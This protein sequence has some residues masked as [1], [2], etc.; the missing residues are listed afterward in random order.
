MS[1]GWRVLSIDH[2]DP[3]APFEE[4]VRLIDVAGTATSAAHSRSDVIEALHDSQPAAVAVS[5]A[6][7]LVGV[8]V[9]RVSGP[10]AHL[11]VLALHPEWR[12]KGIGSALLGRLDQEVVHRGARRMLALVRPGQVGEAAFA[13]QGFERW[14][15][16]DLYE[17]PVSIVPEELAIVEQYGGHFPVA[18][19]WSA[20]KGFSSTKDLIERRV[21]APLA[22]PELADQ[23]GLVPPATILLFGP[24]GTGKTSFARAIASRLSWAFVELH[25]S[26]LGTGIEGALALRQAL[27]DLAGVD[28]LVCF[29]DE[30][31]EIVADR[32]GRPENQA[33][34]NELLKSMPAFKSG[35]ERLMVMA[36]NSVTTIDPAMLRPGRFDLIIP[37][38]APDDA[39]RAELAAELV[40]AS[41]PE[42]IASLTAG[43]TPADFALVAQRSAQRAFDRAVAGGDPTVAGADV[44]AAVAATRPSVTT[45]A[46][47]RFEVESKEY[48]RL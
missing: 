29:I 46:T 47:D 14:R 34:V 36:T 25:P 43:F 33:I 8:A 41:D 2:Q 24:P 7:S 45:E 32:L 19:L 10:D 11:V 27:N 22:K 40:P 30:A 4:V 13:N 17:R 5:S 28:R 3:V 35:T 37:V 39:G 16:L 9:A 23:V 48:A 1:P 6:G 42:E 38:G 31:D 12:G 44:L 21:I 20:M 15:G 26:L 18:G